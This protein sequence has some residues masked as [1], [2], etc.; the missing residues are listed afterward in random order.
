MHLSNNGIH[1]LIGWRQRLLKA[2]LLA[3]L[4]ALGLTLYTDKPAALPDDH[5]Q[6]ITIQ[7]DSAERDEL[8]GTTTYA[9]R[10]LMQ[11][12]SMK[13]EANS[14]VIYNTDDRVTHL[15]ATG[16]PAKYQQ[17]P[18]S[19]Q[20]A[21]EAKANTLE[22]LVNEETLRLIDN[23]SLRQGGTS[24]SGTLI[25]YD[26]KKALVKADSNDEER[27]KMVIPPKAFTADAQET[28]AQAETR[29][30]ST[31]TQVQPEP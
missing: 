27:V 7:S 9:G 29:P 16:L 21:V 14:I 22:Y 17:R 12:G 25:Q 6:S 4:T 2:P 20:E 23:A 24:L 30:L 10:V 13:I 31:E 5:L 19:G 28:A 18:S 8:K 3:M 11:Q 26:V 15:V 1:S